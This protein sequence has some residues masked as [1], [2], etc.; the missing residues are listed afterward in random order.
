[1]DKI[2]WLGE[3]YFAD[4]LPD[5]GWEK[6]FIHRPEKYAIFTYEQ[7]AEMAG[8]A[9]DV[10]V[11]SDFSSPPTMPGIEN[12]PCLTVFYSVDSHLHSWHPF[13]AQ[14]F[15]ACLCSLK[16]HMP[17][18]AGDNLPPERIWWSPAFARDYDYADPN[19]KKIHECSF[20]GTDNEQ[21][22]PKRHKFLAELAA[23]IP[24]FYSGSG[25][26]RKIYNQSKIVVNQAE[27]DDL[28]FRVF[29]AMGCGACLVTPRIG[30]GLNGL[31]QD[32]AHFLGYESGSA[33]DAA[34]KIRFLLENDNARERI[35]LDAYAEVNAKHRA[36]H[37]AR[38]LT[39]KLRNLE[40][41]A[42]NLVNSRLKNAAQLRSSLFSMLYLSFADKLDEDNLKHAFLKAARGALKP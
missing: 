34:A 14:A 21:L 36:I 8:F 4:R 1:M 22:A 26:Y 17:K 24:S 41:K 33:E 23:L 18:F 15:D 12:F 37:R 35:A 9:P 16:D 3:R 19:A 38:I 40:W 28:N 20:V 13:Y 10:V 42:R 11:A 27:H 25:Q 6:V 7:L 30:H 31:F 29:E 5:C 32:G 39:E 2:I